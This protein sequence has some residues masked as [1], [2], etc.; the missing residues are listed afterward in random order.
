MNKIWLIALISILLGMAS[1][2][3]DDPEN[4]IVNNETVYTV[5][6]NSDGGSP[7]PK[8]QRVKAGETVTA[9]T[10][11]PAK[12]GYTFVY[13]YLNGTTT[14]YNFQTPVNGNITLYAKWQAEGGGEGEKTNTFSVYNTETWNKAVNAIKAG[15]NDKS[16]ILNVQ[17]RVIVPPTIRVTEDLPSTYTFGGVENLTITL[18]GSGT[19]DLSGDGFLI[20]LS[21]NGDTRQK[22]VIDGPIL[23]GWRDNEGPLLFLKHADL[24]LKDGK[25]TGNF[26][27]GIELQA[28]GAVYIKDGSTFAM[29]GGEI[30]GN[31]C[32]KYVSCNGGGVFISRSTFNM[33]GG[34]ISGNTC[35]QN[36]YG[37]G[38]GVYMSSG[39]FNMS[40]GTISRNS[41]GGVGGG[42]SIGS[43][44][45]AMTGGVIKGNVADNSNALG[46]GVN[47]H[48]QGR[49]VKTGGIIYGSDAED[50]D[51]N[52]CVF[53]S[54]VHNS[55]GTVVFADV[56]ATVGDA[57]DKHR[58]ITLGETDN[59]STDSDAG[60][61]IG[62]KAP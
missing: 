7:T 1:C 52:K 39:T 26:N 41:S 32:G 13:W 16:Y 45:F 23:Q 62:Y 5:T 9:P 51:Q 3:K 33:S 21:G 31:V 8:L 28:G 29:S 53:R 34:E 25:I 60:W 55:N 19:L 44:T 4:E 48:T 37:D 58:E 43:G 11:N 22:L 15:G 10:G 38:G 2:S 20:C 47:V 18:Q 42:V 40:G 59:I 30:S 56:N 17:S 49:F 24:E 6:F 14:A 50:A 57:D 35:G 61:L 12:A 36:T 46:G 27:S 54:N